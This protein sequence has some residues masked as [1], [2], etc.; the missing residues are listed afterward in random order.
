MSIDMEKQK[1]FIIMLRDGAVFTNMEIQILFSVKNGHDFVCDIVERTDLDIREGHSGSNVCYYL[2]TDVHKEVAGLE[3][4]YQ[5]HQTILSDVE[6][7]VEYQDG[8]YIMWTCPA[9]INNEMCGF[10][11]KVD[12]GDE[13]LIVASTVQCAQC[14]KKYQIKPKAWR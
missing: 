5:A 7:P 2:A 4:M 3:V 10:F 8:H 9:I 6:E 11:H 1:Q 14:G 12:L 13:S